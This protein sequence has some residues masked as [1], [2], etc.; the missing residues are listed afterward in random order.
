MSA[1]TSPEF[2]PSVWEDALCLQADPEM[3]FPEKG[4]SCNNAK[5][6]CLRCPIRE[7]CLED[8]IESGDIYHGVRGAMSPQELQGLAR[9]RG[10]TLLP[11]LPTNSSTSKRPK[12]DEVDHAVV[13]RFVN[14]AG[15]RPDGRRLTHAEGLAV[16]RILKAR[17]TTGWTMEHL[18]NLRPERYRKEAEAIEKAER[19][20]RRRV[21]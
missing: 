21:S 12:E 2:G 10:K 14:H 17:G 18:Y 5:A 13:A 6:V 20:Q 16:Y 19:T 15:E 11:F 3:F 7:L 1:A 9:S 8:A 4:E